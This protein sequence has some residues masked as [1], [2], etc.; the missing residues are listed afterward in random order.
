MLAIILTLAVWAGL[1]LAMLGDEFEIHSL[2]ETKVKDKTK[3]TIVFTVA[4]TNPRS[5]PSIT[6]KQMNG[7]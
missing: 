7:P 6:A 4:R 3:S 5:E 2:G 1:S